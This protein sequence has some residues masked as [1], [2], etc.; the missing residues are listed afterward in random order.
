V[1]LCL[2]PSSII[3]N[4]VSLFRYTN[5]SFTF[6][7]NELS[8]VLTLAIVNNALPHDFTPIRLTLALV[9]VN[10]AR[11]NAV[12]LQVSF[13]IAPVNSPNGVFSFDSSPLAFN[14]FDGAQVSLTV[15]HA[16]GTRGPF[17]FHYFIFTPS[18][19]QIQD[20]SDGS[21]LFSVNQNSAVIILLVI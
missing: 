5:Y 6:A 21:V 7:T 13:S 4:R 8:R 18:G 17:D 12:S 16:F 20:L 19:R 10:G 9:S 14:A 11:L 1:F 15:N 2:S 3:Q